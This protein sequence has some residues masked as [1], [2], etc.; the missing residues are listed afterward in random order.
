LA[1]LLKADPT[2]EDFS[3][4]PKRRQALLN[5][6]IAPGDKNKYLEKI[7]KME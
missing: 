4:Q 5:W 2:G 6:R 1:Q 7:R 3:V